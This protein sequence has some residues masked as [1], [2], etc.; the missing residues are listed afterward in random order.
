MLAIEMCTGGGGQAIGLEQAGFSCAAALEIDKH[1]CATLRLNR[2]DWNVLE[3]D[4]SLFEGQP[5]ANIDLFAAGVP[6]PPFS[7]AGKQL[8]KD[9]ERDLFPEAIRIIGES[10]PKAFM[11]ENVAGFASEKFRFYRQRIID[12]LVDLGY[13]VDAKLLNASNFGVPQLRPRYI[14]VG[15]RDEF[16]PHFCWPLQT[17]CAETVGTTIRDLLAANGWPGVERI[18]QQAKRIAPT[19][20]GGSKKHGGPDLGPT[21]AKRQ[22]AELGIDGKGIANE[23][24][25]LDAPLDL[26]PRL[27]IRM[28]ARLQGF[29]DDWDFV[30]G[31]TASYRQIGN[32][33][34]PPV[35]RAV[36]TQIRRALLKENAAYA[37]NRDKNGQLCF[38]EAKA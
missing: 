8:G 22:W 4:M 35:A 13:S 2:P 23:A 3:Q 21:R 5:Y 20:V 7:M 16:A 27:T 18:V 31:K 17:P 15:L 6:C 9:D 36:A 30:G 12:D 14:I 26:M 19:I 32:A 11:L 24:P 38:M 25:L 34:P 29:P 33:F 1:A 10:K 37:V 28:V